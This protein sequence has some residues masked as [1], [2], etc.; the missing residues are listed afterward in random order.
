[1]TP[2]RAWR[3]RYT[4]GIEIQQKDPI[5]PEDFFVIGQLDADAPSQRSMASAVSDHLLKSCWRTLGETRFDVRTRVQQT[6][7]SGLEVCRCIK[8]EKRYAGPA[9]RLGL[10]P[11]AVCSLAK[12]TW[13]SL[14][15]PSTRL[16]SH[17][18]FGSTTQSSARRRG[19]RK[20]ILLCYA[21]MNTLTDSH[22][23]PWVDLKF[24]F[25]VA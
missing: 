6:L 2:R 19:S 21:A 13:P 7:S 5:D 1:M 4:L 14:W 25:W 20:K 10:V 11:Q 23:V 3:R 16:S 22:S 15:P 9:P 8:A 17:R 24:L 18:S 12:G